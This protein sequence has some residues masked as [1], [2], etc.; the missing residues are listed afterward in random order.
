MYLCVC[1]VLLWIW[2]EVREGGRAEQWNELWPWCIASSAETLEQPDSRLLSCFTFWVDPF[3]IAA[4][5]AGHTCVCGVWG[6]FRLQS[7]MAFNWWPTVVTPLPFF[8]LRKPLNYSLFH[9]PLPQILLPI[10]LLLSAQD[11]WKNLVWEWIMAPAC[12]L[13]C[14]QKVGNAG[15]MEKT[16]YRHL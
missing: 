11:Y 16:L 8:S 1:V 15:V 14:T 2:I 12:A 5:L 9:I 10:M 4:S 7:I 3:H 13:Y 6:G